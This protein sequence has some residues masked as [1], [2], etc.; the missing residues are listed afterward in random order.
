[1]RVSI[2]SVIAYKCMAKELHDER[3][4]ST[5]GFVMLLKILYVIRFVLHFNCIF[6]HNLHVCLDQ[7]HL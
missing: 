4:L 5:S 2:G 6:N 3:P 1:M 7:F